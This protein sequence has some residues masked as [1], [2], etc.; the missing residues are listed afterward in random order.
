MKKSACVVLLIIMLLLAMPPV[1]GAYVYYNPTTQHWYEL[2]SSTP[3][4]AD[5]DAWRDQGLIENTDNPAWY[6][7]WTV[8]ER[9]AV[10]TGGHLVTIN[11]QA[12]NEWLVTTFGSQVRKGVFIGLYQPPGSSE[13]AGGWRWLTGE[14]TSLWANWG[15]GEPNNAPHYE[16]GAENFG[17]MFINWT[18]DGVDQTGRWNDLRFLL[19]KLE[20]GEDYYRYGI[21]E[22]NTNPVPIPPAAWLLGSGLIGLVAIRRRF[23]K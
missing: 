5:W 18:V 1:S 20:L 14:D 22:Y 11:N 6:S 19:S 23:K 17:G 21:A 12:E 2:V 8:A 13:P 15:T 3:T 4:Q 16:Y 9:N 10:A 7:S